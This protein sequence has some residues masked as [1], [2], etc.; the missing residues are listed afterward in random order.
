MINLTF[1]KTRAKNSQPCVCTINKIQLKIQKNL[2]TLANPSIVNSLFYTRASDAADIEVIKCNR[3]HRN[4]HA[5]P[6]LVDFPF[7]TPN[8]MMMAI[9]V[10]MHKQSQDDNRKTQ[11]EPGATACRY[12]IDEGVINAAVPFLA[13]CLALWPFPLIPQKW[14]FLSSTCPV[15]WLAHDTQPT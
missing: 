9:Q 10:R 8:K 12:A 4:K 7:I 15:R 14:L 5:I 13:P 3:M 1:V 6:T 2:R 11:T